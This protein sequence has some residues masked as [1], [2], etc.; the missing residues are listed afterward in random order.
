MWKQEEEKQWERVRETKKTKIL[1]TRLKSETH[2][3]FRV[4]ATNDLIKNVATTQKSHARRSKVMMGAVGGGL[5]VV[6][7]PVAFHLNITHM[8]GVSQE[9]L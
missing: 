6:A 8:Q 7:S 2:Y 5:G 3:Q 4:T 9:N 1:I